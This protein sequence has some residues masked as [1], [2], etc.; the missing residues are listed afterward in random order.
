MVQVVEDLRPGLVGVRVAQHD[1]VDEGVLVALVLG[2]QAPD[3][4]LEVD[5]LRGR[6]LPHLAEGRHFAA[7]S[8][9][10]KIE[11][12]IDFL[13]NGGTEALITDP[14]NLERAIKRE[15]GTWITRS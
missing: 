15:T 8:M 9:A 3:L 2:R 7:G 14:P 13:E 10:P 5:R 4:A 1:R 6:V 11:A 12:V